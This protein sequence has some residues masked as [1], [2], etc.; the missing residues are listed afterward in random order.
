MSD[1]TYEKVL[2]DADGKPLKAYTVIEVK[3]FNINI[4][5]NEIEIICE[6]RA[7]PFISGTERMTFPRATLLELLQ[8]Y[9]AAGKSEEAGDE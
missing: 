9:D 2:L 1:K 7:A 3:P 5:K 8:K 6:W 4:S